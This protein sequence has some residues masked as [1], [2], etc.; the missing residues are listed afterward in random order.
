MCAESVSQQKRRAGRDRVGGWMDGWPI[1]LLPAITTF[2]ACCC[3]Q[4]AASSSSFFFV[5]VRSFCCQ[6][7][8][9]IDCC[10]QPWPFFACCCCCQPSGEWLLPA[11][12]SQAQQSKG[13]VPSSLLHPPIII[14]LFTPSSQCFLGTKKTNNKEKKAAVAKACTGR[15]HIG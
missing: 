6:P 9:F 2:F 4:P 14:H 11:G 3:C 1:L 8:L 10:C 13:A 12:L 7:R 15:H 5:R